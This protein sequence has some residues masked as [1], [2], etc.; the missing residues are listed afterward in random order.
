MTR[1][2]R[3][4]IRFEAQEDGK[5]YYGEPQ[6]SGDI[7]L[8][9]HNRE[10]IKVTPLTSSPLDPSSRLDESQSKTVSRL[11][12]PLSRSEV[13]T[14]RG[15]A[16]QYHPATGSKLAKP[17]VA[18]LFFKPLS[19]LCG[20][21]DDVLLPK[22]TRSEGTEDYEVEICVVIGKRGRDIP[23]GEALNYVLG[24]CTVND[25]T[26]REKLK[27]G[28][29]AGFAKTYDT[30]TPLG[31]AL[32]HPSQLR[33]PMNLDIRTTVNGKTWQESNTRNMVLNIAEL[34]HLCSQGTTLEPGSL[35]MTGS[36]LAPSD[37]P[38]PPYLNHGDEMRVWVEGCGT[39]IN[40][41]V[42][43]TRVPPKAKL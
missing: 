24:Y 2:W 15:M 36:P 42:D 40:K 35:I 41:V 8:K 39:L 4:L 12:S 17:P 37:R 10:Q 5:I 23:I 3:Q 18:S 43:E 22:Y 21:G 1:P 7:G 9:Y 33:D 19:T 27:K 20:P 16:A 26:G 11:L 34:I 31:P 6:Q 38:G 25:M 29:Q 32:I 14:I 30:W 28:G 13:Q